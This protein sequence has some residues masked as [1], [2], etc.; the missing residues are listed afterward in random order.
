MPWFVQAAIAGATSFIATN[1]DDIVILMLFFAQVDATFRPKHIF[2]GQYLGFT[3][4]VALSL[5]GFFGGLVVPKEWIGLLGLIPIAIGI[6]QLLDHQTNGTESQTVTEAL[7]YPEAAQS[8]RFGASLFAPPTVQV[9]TIT[10]ANGGDNVGIYVPLFASSSLPS[11]SIILAVFFVMV[12]VWCCIAYQLTQHPMV[13]QVLTR[14]SSAIVPFVLIGLG[15]F[16]LLDSE[17]YRLLRG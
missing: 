16:I 3:V 11:L 7:Y 8:N 4:L 10:I 17:T 14:R 12:S 13:A 2:I 9:A 1:I 5:P 15:L 6:K